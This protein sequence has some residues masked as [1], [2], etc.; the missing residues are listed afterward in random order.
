MQFQGLCYHQ[1]AWSQL[2][3]NIICL[4]LEPLKITARLFQLKMSQEASLNETCLPLANKAHLK[5]AA[6]KKPC[7]TLLF[8]YLV[9][10]PKLSGFKLIQLFT[11]VPFVDRGF[12]P[13]RFHSLKKHTEVYIKYKLVDLIPQ[14]FLLTNSYILNQPIILVFA[15]HAACYL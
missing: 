6:T 11:L 14:A 7:L 2:F 12:C 10:L 8:L 3:I 4:V 5:N 1:K 9:F 13:I 15:S